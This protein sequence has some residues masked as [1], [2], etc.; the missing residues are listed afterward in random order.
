MECSMSR[1]SDGMAR[2]GRHG[3]AGTVWR[4][5]ARWGSA[6]MARLGVARRG[7]AWLGKAWLG[8]EK[9]PRPCGVIRGQFF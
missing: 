8:K 5:V 7:K 9:T 1:L 6:G 2:R 4:G 3:V